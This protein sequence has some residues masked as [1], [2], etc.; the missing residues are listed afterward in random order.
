MSLSKM[1]CSTLEG[2]CNNYGITISERITDAEKLHQATTDL[3]ATIRAEVEPDIYALTLKNLDSTFAALLSWPSNS[4]RLATATRLERTA[5]QFIIEAW[6]EYAG[7]LMEAFRQPFNDAATR[8]TAGDKTALDVLNELGRARDALALALPANVRN[9]QYDE[10]SRCLFI[11]SVKTLVE[12]MPVRSDVLRRQEGEW[13][14]L[15]LKV[16]GVKL[17]WNSPE[18]QLNIDKAMPN[19]TANEVDAASRSF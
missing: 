2:A 9:R 19:K 6:Q 16:P 8:F 18:D 12:K 13:W 11:P 14:T 3:V 1:E 10:L 5:A 17:Q 15:A 4:V 7:E